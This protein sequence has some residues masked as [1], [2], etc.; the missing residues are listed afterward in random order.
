MRMKL[1]NTTLLRPNTTV[2]VALSGGKDSIS[3]THYLKE[4]AEKLNIKVLAINVEHG[5]RGENSVLDTEFVKEFCAKFSIPLLTYS[6]DAPFYAKTHSLSIEH[7]A[8]ILRYDCFLDAIAQN[9]CD[10]VATA[11]HKSDNF[12]S[13][14]FNLFRGTGL[15]GLSGIKDRREDGIVRPLLAVSKAE[16][17]EY[18]EKNNLPFVTDETNADDE[19]TRNALRHLVVPEIKKIFPDAE[20]AVLRLAQIVK[21]EDE[22]LDD[23]SKSYV[24]IQGEEAKISLSTPDALL[25]RAVIFALK[26]LGV[27]RDWA[28]T[29]VDGVSELKKLSNGNQISLLNDFI[30]C[31]EYDTIVI[32]KRSAYINESTPLFIGNRVLLGQS[33]SIEKVSI[34]QNLKDGFYGDYDKIPTDAVIRTRRDGDKFTKFGGGTKSLGDYLT[35]VKV[36]LRLRDKL[37]VLAS[38]NEVLLIFGV[39]LSN[40]IKVDESTKNIIKFTSEK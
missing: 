25:P 23:L 27:S 32:V 39:A 5:I 30:A 37:L 7:S 33:I 19:Y 4:N 2:G 38:G 36:P 15:K 8:R 13:V 16:I 9:K 10:V 11:H 1:V 24:K 21:G 6:V 17:D 14:L 12:E 35:D 22:F 40:K 26:S 20:S 29:H 3:L 31:K 18:I 28:K 34:P